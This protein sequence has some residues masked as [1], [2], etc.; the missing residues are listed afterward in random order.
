MITQNDL[1][2]LEFGDLVLVGFDHGDVARFH[3]A[4]EQGFDLLFDNLDLALT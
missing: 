4:G 1:T 2:A 3:D